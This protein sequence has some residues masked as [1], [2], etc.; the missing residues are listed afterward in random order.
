MHTGYIHGY[1][2]EVFKVGDNLYIEVT[3]VKNDWEAVVRKS[4]KIVFG[5]SLRKKDDVKIIKKALS[6]GYYYIK[7]KKVFPSIPL[8][9]AMQKFE[10]VARMIHEFNELNETFVF[11]ATP[12]D[13]IEPGTYGKDF[14]IIDVAVPRN[15]SKDMFIKYNGFTIVE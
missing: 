5:Y 15:I 1:K 13:D 9:H 8:L 6:E 11:L 2:Q 4:G 14:I 12:N 3:G 10:K 7:I